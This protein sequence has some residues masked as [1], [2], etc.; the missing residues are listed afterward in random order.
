[1]TI[2]REAMSQNGLENS[3]ANSVNSDIDLKTVSDEVSHPALFG[4]DGAGCGL[5]DP[6]PVGTDE[7]AGQHVLLDNAGGAT[8][9]FPHKLDQD[10]QGF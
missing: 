2:C 5:Y 10:L 1:M 4:P 9:L 3:G 6:P 7:Q 8:I